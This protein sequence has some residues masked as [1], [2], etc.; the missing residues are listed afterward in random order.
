MDLGTAA[1]PPGRFRLISSPP[2]EAFTSRN[3]WRK[4]PGPESLTLVTAIVSSRRASS[5]ST[6]MRTACARA[7][8]RRKFFRPLWFGLSIEIANNCLPPDLNAAWGHPLVLGSI[9]SCEGVARGIGL[10][11]GVRQDCVRCECALSGSVVTCNQK[12]RSRKRQCAV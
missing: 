3:A 6:A 4:D 9:L 1:V 5:A 12:V 10:M 8:L 2:A 11:C 7:A